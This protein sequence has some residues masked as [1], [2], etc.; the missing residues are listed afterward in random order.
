M[1]YG[2]MCDIEAQ[3]NEKGYTLGEKKELIDKLHF[4]LVINYIHGTLTEGEY[5]RALARLNKQV[6][7]YATRRCDSCKTGH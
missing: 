7:K 2:A 5:S 3:L 6:G 1:H 4:G